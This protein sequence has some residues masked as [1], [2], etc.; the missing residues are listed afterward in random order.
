MASIVKQEERV[1]SAAPCWSQLDQHLHAGTGRT[2]PPTLSL[3]GQEEVSHSALDLL[4]KTE[5]Q[6]CTPVLGEKG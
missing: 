1:G 4:P 6:P 3:I 2:Q 5:A